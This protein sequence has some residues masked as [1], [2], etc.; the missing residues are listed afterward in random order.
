LGDVAR[1]KHTV[2]IDVPNHVEREARSV[3]AETDQPYLDV[4]LDMIEIEVV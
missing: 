3:A 1:E 4:V 2:T